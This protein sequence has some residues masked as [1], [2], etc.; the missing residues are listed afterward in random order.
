MHQDSWKREGSLVEQ[1][2]ETLEDHVEDS[3]ASPRAKDRDRLH[4]Q[5]KLAFSWWEQTWEELSGPSINQI[6]LRLLA[7]PGSGHSGEKER[8][9]ETKMGV[10]PKKGQACDT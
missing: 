2:E 6:R 3:F 1:Q 10:R 4:R 8:K 5:S 7:T 9:T